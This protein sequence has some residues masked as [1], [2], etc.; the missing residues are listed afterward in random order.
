MKRLLPIFIVAALS[1]CGGSNETFGTDVDQD[2]RPPTES[3]A[4]STNPIPSP[5]PSPTP[6]PSIKING[7]YKGVF[8][9]VD[10]GIRN[11]LIEDQIYYS[12][13]LTFQDNEL[14]NSKIYYRLKDFVLIGDANNLTFNPTTKKYSLKFKLNEGNVYETDLVINGS[15]TSTSITGYMKIDANQPPIYLIGEKE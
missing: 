10:M 4:P 15:V 14:V 12:V 3:P 9:F 2:N 8:Q 13:T 1:A 7:T 6:S 5:T 11:S